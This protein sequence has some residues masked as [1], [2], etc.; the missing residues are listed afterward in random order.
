MGT[1]GLSVSG[2][3]ETWN[4]LRDRYENKRILA[5]PQLKVLFTLASVKSEA[6]QD[7]KRLQ[8]FDI[9]TSDARH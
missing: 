9:S 1:I 7:I 3:P 8:R 5:N 6:A 4:N 2:F